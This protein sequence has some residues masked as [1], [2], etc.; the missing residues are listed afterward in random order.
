MSLFRIEEG[1]LFRRTWI[2]YPT[3]QAA[4]EASKLLWDE[5]H[6]VR[7]GQIGRRWHVWWSA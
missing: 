2:G 6:V 7:V 1:R 5:G 4:E 3:R